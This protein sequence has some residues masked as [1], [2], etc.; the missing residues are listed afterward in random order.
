MN[1][2]DTKNFDHYNNQ[3]LN[4]VNR[5]YSRNIWSTKFNK[6]GIFT[7]NNMNTSKMTTFMY[8]DNYEMARPGHEKLMYLKK[9]C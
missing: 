3:D 7:C 9:P 4:A 6:A 5:D 1:L 2:L 8:A